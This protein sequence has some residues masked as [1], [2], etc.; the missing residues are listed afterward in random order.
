MISS[1][2]HKVQL[3]KHRCVN[4][5]SGDEYR[6]WAVIRFIQFSPY[7]LGRIRHRQF[8]VRTSEQNTT[9]RFNSW[10]LILDPFM[11]DLLVKLYLKH[12]FMTVNIKEI[13][14]IMTN[15]CSRLSI[16]S[17]WHLMLIVPWYVHWWNYWS[18]RIWIIG[19]A[20]KFLAFLS[21]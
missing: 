15:T 7:L 2:C 1:A 10:V 5:H 13:E 4:L 20:V 14:Y 12:P 19:T 17:F 3:S 8:L 6:P 16:K 9:R 11:S 18:K 21:D